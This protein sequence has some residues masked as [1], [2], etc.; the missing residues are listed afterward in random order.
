MD[1]NELSARRDGV[2]TTQEARE[3]GVSAST[4]SRKVRSGAWKVVAR[5]VYIV[6]GHLRSAR[7]QARIAVL[8]V[9][10]QAALGGLPLRGGLGSTTRNPASTSCSPRLAGHTPDRLP[11]L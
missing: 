11:L 5:G 4:I 10:T 6:A 3:C 2:F 9:H 8:S 1:I 7:A